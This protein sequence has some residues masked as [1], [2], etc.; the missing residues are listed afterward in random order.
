MT[1]HWSLSLVP[2]EKSREPGLVT[3]DV[4]PNALTPLTSVHLRDRLDR[5]TQGVLRYLEE[6]AS[7]EKRVPVR[8][9]SLEI[10]FVL[11]EYDTLWV[12]WVGDAVI[13]SGQVR[14]T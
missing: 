1:N 2:P 7:L 14:A 4:G 5:R 9:M 8:V 11:D 12:S 10:D 6:V 3:G 13:T